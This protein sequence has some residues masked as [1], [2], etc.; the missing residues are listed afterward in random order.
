MN[1]FNSKCSLINYLYFYDSE[2]YAIDYG[3]GMTGPDT[4]D[5]HGRDDT[6]RETRDSGTGDVVHIKVVQNPYYLKS[7]TLTEN[8]SDSGS[9]L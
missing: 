6:E 9:D 7:D 2:P 4:Q 5:D 3:I 8:A 1:I